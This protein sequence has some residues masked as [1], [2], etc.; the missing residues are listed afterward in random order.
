M[1][2]RKKLETIY[3]Y[4]FTIKSNKLVFRVLMLI[5]Y[6]WNYLE[7]GYGFKKIL[8]AKIHGDKWH[9][10]HIPINSTNSINHTV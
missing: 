8:P 7:Y 3:Y 5:L 6:D 1:D 4:H 10:E 2:G 9:I